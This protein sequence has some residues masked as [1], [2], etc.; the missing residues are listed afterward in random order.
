MR[1][2]FF[3]AGDPVPQGSKTPVIR[4]DRAFLIEGKGKM[5]QRHKKWRAQ[6]ARAASDFALAN[7]L[8]P[9]DGPLG[10]SLVFYLPK[11]QSKPKWKLW[12]DTGYDLDKLT[13][14]VLDSL[15]GPIMTNDSR[16]V[17]LEAEK[18]YATVTVGP[19]RETGVF[20]LVWSIP[21]WH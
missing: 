21:E 12:P 11:P 8:D 17:R 6:V 1:P 9:L 5:P 7:S 15:T 16:V 4:G 19:G 2:E 10:V 14:S 20:V 13:R 3:V 18:R